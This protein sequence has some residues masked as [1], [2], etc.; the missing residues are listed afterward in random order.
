VSPSARRL[1]HAIELSLQF[2]ELLPY[3]PE[4]T[5]KAFRLGALPWSLASRLGRITT[6]SILRPGLFVRLSLLPWHRPGTAAVPGSRG[7][8]RGT[9]NSTSRNNL[10]PVQRS[11]RPA[12]S[13]GTN[14]ASLVHSIQVF[15]H[16]VHPGGVQMLGRASQ[17]LLP[18]VIA[19]GLFEPRGHRAPRTRERFT[20][21][22]GAFPALGAAVLAK[23]STRARAR[24]STRSKAWAGSEAAAFVLVLALVL[25]LGLVFAIPFTFA[26]PFAIAFAF[27]PLRTRR[28]A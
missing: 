25:V 19:P 22:F 4:F 16:L 7:T 20:S 5:A 2:L 11:Q 3:F 18:C 17:M 24:V 26:I 14:F 12:L 21:P 10:T 8:R 27:L 1:V 13:L 9:R 6:I 28:W 23:V 15:R